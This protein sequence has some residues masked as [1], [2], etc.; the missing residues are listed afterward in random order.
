MWGN[1]PFKYVN[2]YLSRLHVPNFVRLVRLLFM[3]LN[4]VSTLKNTFYSKLYFFEI[5]FN[6]KSRKINLFYYKIKIYI[7][8]T[9]DVCLCNIKNRY[10]FFLISPLPD[11]IL[12]QF[13]KAALKRDDLIPCRN[14]SSYDCLNVRYGGL[15]L[16][17]GYAWSM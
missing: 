4:Q 8:S 9:R 1:W 3:D 13:L 5:L 10:A 7:Y 11:N 16:P 2:N 6:T 12:T 17:L 14:T 15:P